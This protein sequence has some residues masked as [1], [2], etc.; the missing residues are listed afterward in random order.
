MTL[1]DTVVWRRGTLGDTGCAPSVK[2]ASS[3]YNCLSALGV[4]APMIKTIPNLHDT[5]DRHKSS[6]H[7]SGNGHFP[8][9]YMNPKRILKAKK[10]HTYLIFFCASLCLFGCE[11]VLRVLVTSSAFGFGRTAVRTLLQVG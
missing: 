1:G 9:F 10:E 3:L 6:S 11:G 2:F 5:R 7:P 4:I 8:T